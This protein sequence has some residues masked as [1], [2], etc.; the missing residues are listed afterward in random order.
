MACL[1]SSWS[2][3]KIYENEGELEKDPQ[4]I[5]S[6]HSEILPPVAYNGQCIPSIEE[7]V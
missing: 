3:Q 1:I 5:D 4:A 6:N 7:T 2:K